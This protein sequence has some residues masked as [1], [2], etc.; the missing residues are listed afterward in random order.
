MMATGGLFIELLS[1]KKCVSVLQLGETER[2][3]MV[4]TQPQ[5]THLSPTQQVEITNI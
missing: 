4:D 3:W 1:D 2:W 5:A